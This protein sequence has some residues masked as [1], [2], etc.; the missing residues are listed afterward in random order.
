MTLNPF[1]VLDKI[2]LAVY[3]KLGYLIAKIP[4]SYLN[5]AISVA[6]ALAVV[7][8][9]NKNMYFGIAAVALLI[10]LLF[11]ITKPIVLIYLIFAFIP[12][13]WLNLLGRRFRVITF[14]TILGFVYYGARMIARKMNLPRDSVLLGYVA[15]TCF[16]GFSLINSYDLSVSFT[17]SKYFLLSM[18][19]AFS[20][21][22]AI[23]DR[24]QLKTLFWI[25]VVWG[26]FLSI[27]S[28]LQSTVSIKFYPAYYFRV[29]GIKIVEMYSVQGIRR[30]SGTFESGPRYAMY[31]LG[32]TALVL[33]S[34]WRNYKGRRLL[35]SSLLVLFSL[36]LM[37]SFTRAA[38]L[39]GMM[40]FFLYNLFERNW[41]VFVKSIT[42]VTILS[43][44]LLVLV[45]LVIPMN[46]T[47][48]MMARF[49]TEDDEMYLDRFNFLYNAV[50]AWMEN[51]ILG[52]GV[53]TYTYHSWD[54]MQKY[55]VPWQSL[56]WQINTLAMP[57][58]VPVHNEY[59]RMLAETGIFAL[60]S[61]LFIY[62]FSFKNYFFVMKN[63]KDE[64][65]RTCAIGFAMYL[66]VMIPY[67]FFHEYIMMEPYTSM[68]P[69]IMSVLL[70]KLT[71]K[72][73]EQRET[74]AT[75]KA[76]DLT[77]S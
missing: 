62:I 13:A 56:A 39:F 40:Y 48:A 2:F 55:P 7:L 5:A 53:G 59:G 17:S 6:A 57:H 51:P 25:I 60:I 14:L 42:W 3:E 76:K 47:D 16:C 61:F 43:I 36:G 68:I 20:L 32:P 64:L 29:F 26:A 38:I 37:V 41:K 71:V 63:S 12:I 73:M 67:W 11:M 74:L 52:V 8:A 18:F 69:T 75:L 70:R 1:V 44:I 58:S 27:L 15:Y 45:Y 21:V 66:G 34:L 54:F 9:F 35:W 65:L 31:L 77:P 50:R 22:I 49:Q 19:F 23:E 4:R 46:V 33:V 10:A 72:E 24:N 30:A 28:L